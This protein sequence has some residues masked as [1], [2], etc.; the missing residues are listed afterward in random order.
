MRRPIYKSF[1]SGVSIRLHWDFDSSTCACTCPSSL[2]G[3][4]DEFIDHGAKF[5]GAEAQLVGLAP[6]I[7]ITADVDVF[8]LSWL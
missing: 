4:D 2:I 3:I 1:A 8:D 7:F 5:C 6:G